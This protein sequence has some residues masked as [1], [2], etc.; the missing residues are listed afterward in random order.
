MAT[1]DRAILEKLDTILRSEEVRAQIQPIVERV[2]TEL[3]RKNPPPQN[4]RRGQGARRG[5]RLSVIRVLRD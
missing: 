4:L 1:Q 5:L 3:A 2:R